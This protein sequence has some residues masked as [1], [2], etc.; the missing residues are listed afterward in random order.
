MNKY[1]YLIVILLFI[2]LWAV[3]T[4]MTGSFREDPYSRHDWGDKPSCMAIFPFTYEI[5]NST[6]TIYYGGTCKV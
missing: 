3:Y 4:G 1:D 5:D 6:V 2:I